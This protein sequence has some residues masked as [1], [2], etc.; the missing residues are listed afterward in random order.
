MQI[1]VDAMMF[2]VIAMSRDLDTL[3]LRRIRQLR[4]A[5]R[6]AEVDNI[7]AKLRHKVDNEYSAPLMYALCK[8]LDPPTPDKLAQMHP[9]EIKQVLAG[10]RCSQWA[11]ILALHELG[12]FDA[13]HARIS[14]QEAEVEDEYFDSD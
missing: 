7:E 1:G 8:L 4:A 9:M 3:I 11:C 12:A 10:P 2:R 6:R 14:E 13:S 5:W